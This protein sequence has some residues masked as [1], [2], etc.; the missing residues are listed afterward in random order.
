[1]SFLAK[2]KSKE[3]YKS[4]ISTEPEAT[5]H[6]RLYA[7]RNFEQFVAMTYDDRSIDDVVG[8]LLIIRK[9]KE[10]FEGILYDMIQEWINWNEKS[11]RKLLT[12]RVT[13]SNLRKYLF[14]R[15]IRTN[16]QDIRE[17]LRFPKIPREEKY[18]L[19]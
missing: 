11:D 1:M 14:Y 8:E 17:Y 18:P 12:I 10:K 7:V 3:S 6:C 2:T 4:R 9:E 19:S 15:G 16:E 5:Q 13:F